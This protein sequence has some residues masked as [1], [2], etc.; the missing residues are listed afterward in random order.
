MTYEAFLAR[1]EG[2]RSRGPGRAS[3]LCPA[4]QDRSPSLSVAEGRKGILLRCFAECDKPAIVAALGLTMADLFFDAPSPHGH[5]PIPRPVKIDYTALAFRY[6]LAALDRR[7]RAERVLQTAH[8]IAI[9]QLQD[10]DLDRLIDATAQAYTDL[11]RA[12]LF[13]GV[14]DDLRFKEFSQRA[15]RERHAASQ[16]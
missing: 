15:R 13:E 12:E 4:H 16:R 9:S 6:E 8:G 10:L 11:G 14:S 2:V 3:A 5:Q 7:L 1:L